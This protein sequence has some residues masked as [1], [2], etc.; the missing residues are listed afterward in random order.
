MTKKGFTLVEILAIIVILG[1][2]I[3]IVTPNIFSMLQN[4]KTKAYNNMISTIETA[5]TLYL[6]KNK[7][8]IEET[9]YN[10]RI[11]SITLK[12]LKTKGYL[13][14]DLK[15]PKTNTVLDET[16]TVKITLDIDENYIVC[17][18][19]TSCVDPL[20][21][22]DTSGANVP[23]LQ[24]NMIPVY[25]DTATSTWKK[26][27]KFNNA[28]SYQWYNYANQMWANAVTVVESKRKE[29]QDASYG[30]EILMNDILTFFVWIPRYKYAIPAG[31]GARAINI[32]FEAKSTPK[33]TG[34]AIGTNYYTHPAF[35]FGTVEQSGI[36]V[37]KFKSGYL[38]ATTVEGAQI[39]NVDSNKIIIKPNVFSW[40]KGSLKTY[41]TVTRKMQETNNIYGF[42][43]TG[44]NTHLLKNL[45][46]GAVAYLTSSIYG[47]SDEVWINNDS[48][49]HTGCAGASVSAADNA[50]CVYQYNNLT[51]GI[52]ASTTSNIYGVYDMSGGTAE[53]VMGNYNNLISNSDFINMPESKYYN[54]Y[55]SSTTIT[56]DATTETSGWYSDS[57]S[58]ISATAPWM[59]RSGSASLTTSAGLYHYLD[60]TG[61]K[62][63]N[64]TFRVAITEDL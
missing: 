31:T 4:S 52:K 36:W 40:R 10:S 60:R 57:A 5:G 3:V 37:G 47:R 7:T 46:W 17:Y 41:F 59:L 25:Y 34:N 12:D 58:L 24:S 64:K 32:V 45:E 14:K 51:Y 8:T 44:I 27:N 19:E 11:F 28:G 53:W 22:A 54:L 30:Q 29:Y 21:T 48:T 15:N 9:I 62:F 23:L 6:N 56:G 16:K 33:A 1:V 63:Y 61:D 49:F 38:G 55:T 20:A 35:T 39:N 43:P 50:G 26:A 18:E 13:K 2:L 42:S